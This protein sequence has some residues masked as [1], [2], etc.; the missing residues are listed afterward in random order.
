M[1]P[2]VEAVAPACRSRAPSRQG[3]RVNHLVRRQWRCLL[4]QGRIIHHITW[5]GVGGAGKGAVRKLRGEVTVLS[6]WQ[7]FVEMR[8]G[9]G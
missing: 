7:R 6:S 4:I 9:W 2:G 3:P 5:S 1:G 8:E